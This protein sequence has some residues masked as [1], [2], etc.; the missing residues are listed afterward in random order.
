M[1]NLKTIPPAVAAL[2]P[3]VQLKITKESFEDF[4]PSILELQA[5]LEKC[6]KIGETD[7]MKEHPAIFHYFFGSTDIYICEYDRDDYMFGFA[8]LGGDLH[9]SEWG[10]FLL[11]GLTTIKQYNIDYHFQEQSIEAALYTAYPE[12]YKKPQSVTA[13]AQ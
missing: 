1:E 3:K 11:S 6:P 5:Q 4:S 10:Y 9:N 7:G 2:I 12:Y 8:I 13:K